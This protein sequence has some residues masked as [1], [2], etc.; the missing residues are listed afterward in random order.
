MRTA[1]MIEEVVAETS[2][3]TVFATQKGG[4]AGHQY[5][6]LENWVNYHLVT[7]TK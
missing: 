4:Q 3:K 6:H 2:Q 7:L 5:L 1:I